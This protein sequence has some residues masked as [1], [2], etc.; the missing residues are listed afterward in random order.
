MVAPSPPAGRHAVPR[1]AED[2]T[3]QQLQTWTFVTVDRHNRRLAISVRGQASPG[4]FIKASIRP[5]A[6]G[7]LSRGV[8]LHHVW[9]TNSPNWHQQLFSLAP[10]KV[11]LA[12][13]SSAR[14]T[15][16]YKDTFG[17]GAVH[18]AEPAVYACLCHILHWVAM[19]HSA[20]HDI[21]T[22]YRSKTAEVENPELH[23]P[24]EVTYTAS[25]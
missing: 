25:M 22:S 1:A 21:V 23:H 15:V 11:I 24:R 19:I 2:V 10:C 6:I 5:S 17:H 8:S 3:F 12:T 20:K 14:R 9:S 7:V 4:S 16:L 18:P 13:T